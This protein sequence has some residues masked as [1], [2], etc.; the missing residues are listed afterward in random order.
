MTDFLS[1]L[2]WKTKPEKKKHNVYLHSTLIKAVTNKDG[3]EKHFCPKQIFHYFIA[4]DY[5]RVRSQYM[6]WGTFAEELI[7]GHSA[8]DDNDEVTTPPR[9]KITGR[10]LVNEV[11][12]RE[13]MMRVQNHVFPSK[14]ISCIPEVNTQIKVYKDF[15]GYP[16]RVIYDIFP[17]GIIYV[18]PDTGEKRYSVTILDLKM[19][20]DIHNT[21][22]DFCWGTPEY[23]DHLQADL[24]TWAIE[25][26]DFDYNDLHNPGN[27]LRELCNE[28]VMSAIK[29]K[30]IKF[31]YAVV[32]YKKEPLEEQIMFK[33]RLRSESPGNNLRR[34]EL[35]E[36]MRKAVSILDDIQ[37][38]GYPFN[39]SFSNCANCAASKLKGGYCEYYSNVEKI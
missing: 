13:Q 11:R 16:V 27:N 24:Y 12:I 34:K 8:Y 32:G 19:T 39:P 28:L 10:P 35:L 36:R 3:T 33:E 38:E 30:E 25:D 20:E 17:T 9:H 37:M 31:H 14:G 7:L 29:N 22:G 1:N 23:M 18:D 21:F 6:M 15:D 4:R 5:Q 2:P 26:I